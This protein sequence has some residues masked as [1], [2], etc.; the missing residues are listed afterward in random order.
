MTC[1]LEG[2]TPPAQG[3]AEVYVEALRLLP[4]SYKDRLNVA[5][6]AGYLAVHGRNLSKISR[7]MRRDRKWVRQRVEAA[8]RLFRPVLGAYGL[9][10][11][12]TED[13]EGSF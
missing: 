1:P 9:H 7:L 12:A 2:A 5:T 11:A 4:L 3:S 10:D 8:E 6:V 13:E